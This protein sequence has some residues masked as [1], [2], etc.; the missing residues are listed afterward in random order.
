MSQEPVK[1][2]H[3][4]FK[5]MDQNGDGFIDPE[6]LKICMNTLGFEF[7]AAE[8]QHLVMELDP[9]NTGKIDMQHFSEF[10]RSKMTERDHIEE[11]Q[12]AFQML[13]IDKKGKITFSD[14]KKVAKELGENITDQELHEMINEA[15]TDND[16][17]ISFEE[18]V[19]L[20][21]TAAPNL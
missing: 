8:I 11:I 5:D 15:D 12:M 14:L 19:A 20:I 9:E 3:E 4:V 17:E 21:K 18:F 16:G 10:I 13:D 7:N 1:E 2:I 6:D